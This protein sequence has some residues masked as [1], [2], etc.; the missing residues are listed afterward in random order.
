MGIGPRRRR[1]VAQGDEILGIAADRD[2]RHALA[3]PSGIASRKL[4]VLPFGNRGDEARAAHGPRFQSQREPMRGAGLR[5]GRA[6]GAVGG[7]PGVLKIEH[8]RQAE[9]IAD[10]AREQHWIE[11]RSRD[12]RG[13]GRLARGEPGE[14]APERPV[15][16]QADVADAEPAREPR[17]RGADADLFDVGR[18]Q[19]GE[20]GI[21]GLLVMGLVDAQHERPPAVRRQMLG[22]MARRGEPRPMPRAG[23]TGRR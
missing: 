2:R 5:P 1:R 12:E 18:Q 9:P 6:R 11:R 19:R 8:D 7:H 15:A 21:G 16:A 3:R 20:G 17:R 13:V 22:E 4:V 10:E 14:R 23:N